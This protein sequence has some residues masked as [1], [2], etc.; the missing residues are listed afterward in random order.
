MAPPFGIYYNL[1]LPMKGSMI[2]LLVKPVGL[3]VHCVY[4]LG[5]K[6]LYVT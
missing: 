5:T 1:G 2:R 3:L 4:T 6:T